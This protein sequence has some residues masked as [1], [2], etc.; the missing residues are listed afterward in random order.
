[1]L[2]RLERGDFYL[3]CSDNEVSPEADRKRIAWAAQDIIANRSALS[4]WHPDF[5]ERFSA[6]ERPD[7]E[8]EKV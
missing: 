6:F 4:P 2:K 3:L 8:V 7:R 1:M 5:A